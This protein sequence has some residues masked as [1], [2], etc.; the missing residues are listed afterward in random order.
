[1]IL[2]RCLSRYM[3]YGNNFYSH[4]MIMT[5]CEHNRIVS[6]IGKYTHS[7]QNKPSYFIRILKLQ[8]LCLI[9]IQDKLFKIFC[10]RRINN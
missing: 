3:T 10:F 1:M 7:V 8:L 4:F 2:H 5:L 9:N 6:R